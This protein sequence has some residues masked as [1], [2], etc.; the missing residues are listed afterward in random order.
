MPSRSTPPQEASEAHAPTEDQPSSLTDIDEL[1]TR[2]RAAHDHGI[3]IEELHAHLR[4]II[5]QSGAGPL[6]G[7]ETQT[8]PCTEKSDEITAMPEDI[9][10]DLR[11][12]PL[13]GT[14][15]SQSIENVGGSSQ[16]GPLKSFCYDKLLRFGTDSPQRKSQESAGYGPRGCYGFSQN[17]SSSPSSSPSSLSS[18][19]SSY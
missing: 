2:L 8:P 10:E 11:R 13:L 7:L 9:S 1:I 4:P 15:Y 17:S 16:D 3:T 5:A 18:S 14:S 19:S 12:N 6:L